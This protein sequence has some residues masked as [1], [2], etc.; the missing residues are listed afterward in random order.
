[1]DEGQVGRHCI[2]IHTTSLLIT[3]AQGSLISMSAHMRIC[4]PL[5]PSGCTS[6]RGVSEVGAPRCTLR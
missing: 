3:P 5:P 2:H 6:A 1:M 4:I